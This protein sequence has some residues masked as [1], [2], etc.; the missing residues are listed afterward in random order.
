MMQQDLENVFGTIGSLENQ[1]WPE[2]VNPFEATS[3]D[4]GFIGSDSGYNPFQ[5]GDQS[6]GINPG[7]D[8]FDGGKSFIGK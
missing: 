5:G 3:F 1:P 2:V 6:I 7:G 8:V 4:Q